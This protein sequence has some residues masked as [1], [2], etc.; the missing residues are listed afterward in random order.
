MNF[1]NTFRSELAPFAS[2]Y[3]ALKEAL[4]RR[5][6]N[7]RA[8]LRHLD[9]FL[10]GWSRGPSTLTAETFAVW[11]ATFQHLTPTVRRNRMRIVRNLCLYRR[12]REP[13]CFVPDPAGFPQ[14]HQTKPAHIFTDQ[15]IV[16]LLEA[17]DQL[18]R[19]PTSPL[20]REGLRLAIVLLY[21]SGLRRGEVVR[22]TLGDYD[23]AQQ[24]LHICHSKFHKSRVVPLSS[25]AAREI[26]GYLRARCRLP[27]AA[28]A[29]LLCNCHGGLRPYTGAGLAQAIERLFE[30]AGIRTARGRL[31]RIHDLRHTF[32]VHALRRWYQEGV[33]VQAKLPSLAAYMG[34]VSI[35][36]TQRYLAVAEPFSD[37]VAERFA[38]HCQSFLGATPRGGRL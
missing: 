4:G 15:Q 7:E 16:Q 29:P 18:R 26:D 34:H 21:T 22:L 19:A 28:P 32:A 9:A 25:Q 1:A 5:Y 31:P 11:I 20:Y 35:L 27:Q 37:Q 36:S 2:D 3:L 12:R 33:D 14:P 30:H 10:A 6:R 13:D 23:G 38:R 24:T 8:V 17:A